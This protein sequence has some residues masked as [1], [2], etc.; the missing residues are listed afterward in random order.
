MIK[1]KNIIQQKMP[2]RFMKNSQKFGIFAMQMKN[3][4]LIAVL[5]KNILKMNKKKPRARSN[6]GKVSS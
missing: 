5:Y 4:G 3:E 1:V 2:E 6:V